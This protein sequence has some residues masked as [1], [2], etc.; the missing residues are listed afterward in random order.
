MPEQELTRRAMYDLVCS[1]PMTKVA[2]D[3]GIRRLRQKQKA[4]SGDHDPCGAFTT[5]GPLRCARDGR[6]MAETG[7]PFTGSVHDR[8]VRQRRTRLRECLKLVLLYEGNRRPGF[9]RFNHRMAKFVVRAPVLD[10]P[11]FDLSQG[12]DAIRRRSWS[13]RTMR[14]S[15]A[16]I[17][18]A[19]RG[20]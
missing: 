14:N 12:E 20:A 8:P 1:R 3:L 6:R 2:E 17:S 9:A 15:F 7:I 5:F 18:S 10:A 11:N 16:R 19:R 4:C 13:D